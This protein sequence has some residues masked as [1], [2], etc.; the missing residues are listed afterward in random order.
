PRPGEISL[1]HNGVLFLDELTEFRRNV[2]ESL[3]QP[4]ETH[5]VTISRAQYRFAYPARFLL[6][7]AMNPC[8]CGQLGNPQASCR[9]PAAAVERYQGTL[10]G[11]L[12]DRF[13]LK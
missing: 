3:R 5:N 2:L 7:A 9:C 12:L 6:T 10:S 4:L 13:D 11:P 8:P 1:A